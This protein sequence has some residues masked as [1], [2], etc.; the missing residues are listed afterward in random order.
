MTYRDRAILAQRLLLEAKGE[1]AD[2][3]IDAAVWH[4]FLLELEIVNRWWSLSPRGYRDLYPLGQSS[5]C[6]LLPCFP[7]AAVGAAVGERV[8]VDAYPMVAVRGSTHTSNALARA[9]YPGGEGLG[10]SRSERLR[11]V[12]RHRSWCL[13]AGACERCGNRIDVI[14]PNL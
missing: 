14:W 5:L 1:R 8:W 11:R 7:C 9:R 13:H 10:Y 12:E 2:E 6:G 3:W 4:R